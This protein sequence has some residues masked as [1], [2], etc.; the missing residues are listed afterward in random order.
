[1]CVAVNEI[2]LKALPMTYNSGIAFW[3]SPVYRASHS[4]P[5][6]F[7]RNLRGLQTYVEQV[8]FSCS[9]SRSLI[10]ISR[11]PE[12]QAQL[13]TLNQAQLTKLKQLSIVSLAN[14]SR[15]LAFTE[16]NTACLMI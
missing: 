8:D 1:M 7:I 10:A 12:N 16:L 11:L 9:E 2:V 15:V 6:I 13:P 3:E 4:S 14:Q 5:D